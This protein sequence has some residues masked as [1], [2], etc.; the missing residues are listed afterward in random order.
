MKVEKSSK[1]S[2]SS[3]VNKTALVKTEE[4]PKISF[5]EILAVKDYD[6]QKQE[7]Q[8]ALDEI[9][10]KGQDLV[11]NRT[12]ENLYAYKDLIKGFIEETV[13][14]GLEIKERRGFSR[15]GRTKVMRT[16]AEVDAKL[17]ELTNLILKREHKEINVLKKVGEIQGLLVNIMI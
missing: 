8:K 6:Q 4:K 17:L 16:V 5:T 1:T 15:S 2:K 9:D 11:E 14:K 10:K 7:L 3:S 13:L 12:V